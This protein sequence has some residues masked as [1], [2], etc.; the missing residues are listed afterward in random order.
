MAVNALLSYIIPDIPH[1]VQ[2]ELNFQQH[3]FKQLRMKALHETYMKQRGKR[4]RDPSESFTFQSKH[5][6]IKCP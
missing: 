3:Q 4:R 1:A 6:A 2:E 5:M